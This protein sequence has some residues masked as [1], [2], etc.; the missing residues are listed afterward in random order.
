[1]DDLTHQEKKELLYKLLMEAT[2]EELKMW[3]QDGGIFDGDETGQDLVKD[4]ID[5]AIAESN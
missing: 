5:A 2:P 4:V 1:M 3:L